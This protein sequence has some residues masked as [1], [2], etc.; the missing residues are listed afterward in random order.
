MTITRCPWGD[1]ADTLMRDYHDNQWGKPCFDERELFEMLIL[2]G[3]QAGLSWSCILHKRENCRAAFDDFEA[4]IVASYDECKVAAL[5]Q[6]SGI[7]RNKLKINAAI[8]N[9]QA[10]LR[11]GSLRDFIWG[12]VD[13]KQIVNNWKLQGE[14]P[15]T[16]PLSDTISKDMKKRGFKFVGST[17]V[18]S[19]LQAIGVVNDHIESC[20]F[21]CDHSK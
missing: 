12:Y 8:T 5:L 13:G 15:S 16:T 21:K 1:T 19:Y 9:A 7:I 10:V 14:M 11:L 3:M 18:Y 6:D 2:E 4:S 17:I 20:A